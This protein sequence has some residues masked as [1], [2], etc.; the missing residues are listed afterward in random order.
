LDE[1]ADTL[2][3]EVFSGR[4]ELRRPAPLKINPPELDVVVPLPP[5]PET[6]EQPKG[7]FEITFV[8]EVGAAIADRELAFN[9]LGKVEKKKTDASGKAR[10]DQQP[11]SIASVKVA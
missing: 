5:P 7:L 2:E 11:R 3:R 6:E 4:A 1:L 9:V 8:D 10:L